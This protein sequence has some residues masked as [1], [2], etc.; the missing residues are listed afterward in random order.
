VFSEAMRRFEGEVLE[1]F[2]AV[3]EREEDELLHCCFCS[4][5]KEHEF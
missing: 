5:E 4:E 2:F 1:K 3:Q